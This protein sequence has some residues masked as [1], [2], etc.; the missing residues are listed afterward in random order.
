MSTPT[1]YSGQESVKTALVS[2]YVRQKTDLGSTPVSTV[3]FNEY[4][5]GRDITTVLTL[6]N[7]V[8]GTLAGAAAAL[9][10]GNIVYSFP[11]S[12]SQHLEL[13]YAFSNLTATAAG[14]A[15]TG[16]VGL[17]SV[18]ASGAVAVLSGTAT[19]QN[20]VT[21]QAITTGPT[22]GTAIAALTGATAG[23]GTGISLNVAANVKNVFLNT[24][25]TWAADNTGSLLYN[26]QII[27]KWTLMGAGASS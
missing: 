14:T 27:L 25:A 1:A 5:D 26:G 18:I 12:P 17:G 6:T 22:G 23:I 10:V 3:T 9:G 21:A 2:N 15:T 19:F 16:V 24:A 20:R 11:A 13:V 8:G 4:G 7:F